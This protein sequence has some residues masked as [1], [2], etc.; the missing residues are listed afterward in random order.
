[1]ENVK[2][3]YQ[4]VSNNKEETQCI[5]LTEKAGQF[6]GVVYKYGKVTI[7]DPNE[8]SG[9]SDLPLSFHYDIVDSNNLPRNWL[10][11]PEFQRVIGD[12]LVDILDDQVKEGTVQFANTN[13]E[14]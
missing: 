6:Q 12:I 13:T 8:L 7:P 14:D 4:Y 11:T 9:E 5:G 1:M 3:L 10:E 2:Q